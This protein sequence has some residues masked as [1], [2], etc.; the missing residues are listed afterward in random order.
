MK[1]NNDMILTVNE[2]FQSSQLRIRLSE[3][4]MERMAA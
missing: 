4:M 2:N 1:L 3:E